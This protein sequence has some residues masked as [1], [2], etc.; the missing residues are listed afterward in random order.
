MALHFDLFRRLEPRRPAGNLDLGF[1]ARV[2]DPAWFL[3]RQWQLGEHQGEDAGSPV[4]ISYAATQLPIDP[5]N[6]DP[7][8]DPLVIPPEVIVESEPDDWW[9]TGRRVR[10]GRAAAPHLPGGLTP[11]EDTGLRLGSLAPPYDGFS[12]D[13]D[14]LACY[15]ARAGLGLPATV[16][17]EV[18]STVPADL[19]DP[20]ELVYSASFTTGAG[21][22]PILDVPRHDG[23]DLDWYSVRSPS[24]ATDLSAVSVTTQLTGDVLPNRMEYPGAPQPRWWQIE[25][26]KVDVGGFPPDRSH[27]ATMLLIDL[28]VSHADDWFSFPVLA[29]AGTVVT[30]DSVRIRDTFEDVIEAHAPAD[31]TL[32]DVT[33][34]PVSSLVVWPTVAT[35]L[36][37]TVLDEVIVGVDEDANLLW[38]IERRAGARELAAAPAAPV[39]PGP[40]PAGTIDAG[41]RKSYT[42]QPSSSVAAYWHP[43]EIHEIDGRRRFVQS[44]LADLRTRP[45]TLMPEPVSDLLA[46][47]H[48]PAAGPVHQIEPA[49][50]P[51]SGLRLERRYLLGRASDGRPVLW[52]QRR[53]LPLL[54]PPVS[55]LR[56]DILEQQPPL[57]QAP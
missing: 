28:V 18:P 46:D 52:R 55:G 42:Y 6:G 16:F 10:L 45:P 4:M 2:A 37:G 15:R 36:S 8:L 35:P 21:T 49:T 13:Y 40:S 32:F 50:V 3:A 33:G 12:G 7:G 23:G 5:L 26:A 51:T 43:Y 24:A 11:D 30:I 53:R 9:T 57:G 20:A 44:R 41:T 25:D 27:L 48:A 17:A 39:D 34:L 47:P 29:T 1:Q 14:G 38:A 22:G 56:F 54:T 19:W 31:W